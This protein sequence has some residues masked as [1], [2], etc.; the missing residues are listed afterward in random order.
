[1]IDIH[2]LGKQ[3]E[4]LAVQHL[5]SKGYKVKERNW[6]AGILEIDI[7]AEYKG[8]IV[9]VEVRTRSDN[10]LLGPTETVTKQKQ[11]SIIRAANL[12]LLR[13]DIDKECR[14]DIISVILQNG[15]STIDHIEDAFYARL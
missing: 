9:I 5:V 11:R 7:I 10:Y 6:R 3:G 1:M 14:F 13:H 15:E 8:V 2:E 4:D 12:Y